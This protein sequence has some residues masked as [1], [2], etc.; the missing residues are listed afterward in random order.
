[1]LKTIF[2]KETREDLIKRI[3]NLSS[4]NTAQWGKMNVY[5]MVKH[6]CIWNAWIQDK[7]SSINKQTLLGYIFG[8]MALKSLIE[9]DRPMKKNMPA[10][11]AFSV[12]EKTGDL[13]LQKKIW[14]DLLRGY[15]NFS[16]HGFVHDF[17][18]KMTTE[19]IGLLAYKHTDHHLRQFNA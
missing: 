3:D 13:S 6:N 11:K 18:G 9:D 5:Q 14:A 15:E 7:N 12:K 2:D 8:K 16:N 4:H 17:F 1:M 10:G 19:E